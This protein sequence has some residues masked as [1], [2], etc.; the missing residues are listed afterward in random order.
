MGKERAVPRVVCC[1]I[2][3]ARGAGQVLLIT[4]R[5]RPDMWVCEY[6]FLAAFPII[7]HIQCSTTVNDQKKNQLRVCLTS[8]SNLVTDDAFY[9][10]FLYIDLHGSTTGSSSDPK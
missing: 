1:A 5:S 2:P 4:S 9:L 6:G 7:H 10:F 3:I 8:F